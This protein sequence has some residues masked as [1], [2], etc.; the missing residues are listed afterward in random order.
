[1]PIIQ[2][3]IGNAYYNNGFIN[4][5]VGHADNFG[6][7]GDIIHVYLGIW[8][9]PSIPCNVNRTINPNQTPRIYIGTLFTQWIQQNH[10]MGQV[11]FVIYGESDFPNSILI[12]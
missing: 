11:L 10:V 9:D 7:H 1:M 12:Q 3:N 8:D 6:V 4:I 5:P 2:I